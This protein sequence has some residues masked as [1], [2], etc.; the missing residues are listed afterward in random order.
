M[1]CSVTGGKTNWFSNDNF[2]FSYLVTPGDNNTHCGTHFQGS[3]ACRDSCCQIQF[4]DFTILYDM[5][6]KKKVLYPKIVV[7]IT[8]L[9]IVLIIS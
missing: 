2:D 5:L 9:I 8:Y 3:N 6:K 1:Y 7:I 4:D